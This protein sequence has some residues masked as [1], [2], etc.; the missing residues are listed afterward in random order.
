MMEK[1]IDRIREKTGI[2]RLA[3][4]ERKKLFEEFVEHGGKVEEEK[5][6]PTGTILRS[7]Q[8]AQAPVHPQEAEAKKDVRLSAVPAGTKEET[9]GEREK[10]AKKRKKSKLRDRIGIY[11]RG[12]ML[13]VFTASGR[14]F[15]EG[16]VHFVHKQIKESLLDLKVTIDSFLYGENT[17]KKEILRL[18]TAENSTFYEFLIRMGEL[19]NEEEFTLILNAIAVRTIPKKESIDVFKSFFK[20]MYIIG[21][22]SDLCKLYMDKSL[23]LQTKKKLLNAEMV[24]SMRM[25]LKKDINSILTDLLLRIHI[26]MCKIDRTYYPLFS[27][28][29]DDFLEMTEMDRIGY[30]TEKERKSRLEELKQQKKYLMQQRFYERGFDKEEVKVPKHVERGFELLNSVLDG[31][32]KQREQNEHN[33]VFLLDQKDKMFK[34]IVFFED[35]DD[36]YS[37][38]LTTS[39]ISFNIDYREQKKIDVKRDL[40][41][42]YLLFSEAREEVKNYMDII[43]ESKKT[44]DNLRLTEHQ[45]QMSLESLSKKRSVSSKAARIRLADVMKTIENSLS[46]VISDYNHTKR[47][48]QNSDGVL[49]FDTHIDGMKRLHGKKI[50]EA[51]IESFLYASSFAFLLNY[52]ELAGSGLFIESEDE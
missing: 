15:T 6:H 10:A 17:I 11:V 48:L 38:I 5:K 33:P 23:D 20:R 36:Q 9:I 31:L 27:Q 25:Q 47:I 50:I 45:K 22:Y 19:Y 46:V 3:S 44:E 40:S 4:D 39:K 7:M 14:R 24:P 34:S 8:R 35:F 42:A 2:D 18:S 41:N 1:D 21:Q 12:L 13:K 49:L 43:K 51:I 32:E 29:L 26:I 52:G 30:I 16:F 28:K 37:F